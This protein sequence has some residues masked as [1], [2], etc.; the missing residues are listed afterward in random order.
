MTQDTRRTTQDPRDKIRSKKRFLVFVFCVMCFV[1]C[2]FFSSCG[3]TTSSTLPS[4]IKTIYI[5]P[6]KNK[7]DFTTGTSR[8]IYLPLLEVDTRNMV[9]DRFVFDGNLKIAKS[10][11]ADLILKGELKKYERSALR[12]TDDDDVQEYRVHITVSF[13]LWDTGAEEPSWTE[14]NFVGEATYFVTGPEATSEESAVDEA[15]VDLARRIVER[16][17]ENW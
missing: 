16:T 11:E 17:I 6:F 2:V 10:H 9:I 4:N 8:N 14:K 12:Y 5:E 13:E 1:S 7:I 3:Y 15:T